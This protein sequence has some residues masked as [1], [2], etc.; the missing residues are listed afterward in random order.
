M[1]SFSDI[2]ETLTLQRIL[3]P[4]LP[5]LELVEKKLQ[6]ISSDCEGL[7]KESSHYVL[8]SGGKRL[9]A[10]L[11]LFC[12]AIGSQEAKL[13]DS[14]LE[15]AV[16][17]AVAVEMIHAATLVHDD[18]LDRSVLRRL[19]PTVNVQFGEEVAILLGDFLY[20][21]AFPLLVSLN[22]P[23]ILLW[24]THSTQEVCDGEISQ[25]KNRYRLNLSQEEYLTFIRKKTASLIAV[26]AKSGARLGNLKTE[27]VQSL[28]NF[29]LHIGTTFQIVDDLL[30]VIGT[31]K[32]LGK[33]PHNDASN[34][35]LTLP[36][37]LLLQQALPE[38]KQQFKNLFESTDGDWTSI[39]NL[40]TKYRI[41]EKTDAIAA[42]FFAQAQSELK[43]FNSATQTSFQ[44]LSRFIL[45]RNY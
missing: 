9:R 40:L 30:D 22:V 36:M 3:A 38:E 8:S 42:Q 25:L 5:Q 29:G 45:K 27:Q 24:I 12:C 44:E 17:L 19:R 1:K 28:Y 37:I 15:K 4:I 18:V 6:S 43:T 20:T 13:D 11:V 32:N 7:L 33:T 14:Q 31:E 26:S 41:A 10:A 23:E 39:Q 21:R 16:D 34:G 35:K 2:S